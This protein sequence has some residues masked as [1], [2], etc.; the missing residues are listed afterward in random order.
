MTNVFVLFHVKS[1]T[2]GC[3]FAS[4]CSM[5]AV[6][7]FR[8]YHERSLVR[9]ACE[10]E[11]LQVG[12]ISMVYPDFRVNLCCNLTNPPFHTGESLSKNLTVP[13]YNVNT[14]LAETYMKLA[15]YFP[16]SC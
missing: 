7:P 5:Q 10:K 16:S 3:N 14:P 2:K 11:S 6:V 13:Q 8:R 9:A 15:S 4:V 12:S 1:K